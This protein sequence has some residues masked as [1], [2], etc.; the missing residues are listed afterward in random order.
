[1]STIT[2][3]GDYGQAPYRIT[4]LAPG[5][6]IDA[7]Q[8]SWTLDNSILDGDGSNNYPFRV[9]NSGSNVV[10]NG[11][12]IRGEVSLTEDW[13]TVYYP[14]SGNGNSAGVRVSGTDFVTIQ[15]WRMTQI[16]D[17]LRV[18]DGAENF[19]IQNVWVMDA[20]DDAIENDNAVTGTIRDSLFDGVFAGMSLDGDYDGSMN[21]VTMDGVLMR[22]ESYLY[23]GKVTHGSPIKADSGNPAGTPDLKFFSTVFAI[24]RVDHESQGRLKIAWDNTVQSENCYFLN[25]SDT[26][27]PASYPK[28]PAGWTILEGQAARDYWAQARDKWIADH[29]GGG[30]TNPTPIDLVPDAVEDFALTT[31]DQPVAIADVTGNDNAGNG[32]ASISFYDAATAMGGAVSLAGADFTYTPQAGF[33]GTDSFTYTLTD[34]D[35]DTDTATVSVTVLSPTGTGLPRS[36][37]IEK[38]IETGADD[39]EQRGRSVDLDSSDLELVKDGS[40]TQVV[41][42]RFTGIEIP[43]GATITRAWVTFTCDETGSTA[44]NL[45]IRGNDIGDAPTFAD[46]KNNVSGRAITDAFATWTPEAWTR[47]G[48]THNTSDISAIISE[49]TGRTDWASGND[50]ALIFSGTGPRTAEAFESGAATA[51]LLYV[52]Y[53]I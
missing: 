12:T 33:V 17:A 34:G 52:E 3:S 36:R 9:D 4:N 14:S 35:G 47:V 11:G 6:V 5:T 40:T 41:G 7:S 21:T 38:R 43:K 27:L 30:P 42:L 16:W 22:M 29:T 44:T 28:P 13:Q 37:T 18:T 31:M 51:P 26:P 1:M 49:I 23:K 45:T 25:L 48:Q 53:V 15:N 10:I 46:T 2:L 8:A 50:L 32:P 39:V 19:L 20:R 24:E